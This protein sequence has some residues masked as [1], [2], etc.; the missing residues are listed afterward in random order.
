MKEVSGKP[1]VIFN[2]QPK[3]YKVY[4]TPEEL[5]EWERLMKEEVGFKADISNLSG[6]CTESTSAG[7]SDDCDQD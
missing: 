2:F 5:K 4:E 6:S 3:G 7:R 1:P